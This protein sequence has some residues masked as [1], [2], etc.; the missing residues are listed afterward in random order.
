M[1]GGR[2]FARNFH[3]PIPLIEENAAISD[4]RNY[5]QEFIEQGS[6]TEWNNPR[7]VT[8]TYRLEPVQDILKAAF[9][10]IIAFFHMNQA[11]RIEWLNQRVKI[12][13][14]YSEEEKE[15]L[16]QSHL[17]QPIPTIR[18]VILT[19]YMDEEH[20]VHRLQLSFCLPC[21]YHGTDRW[22]VA[23]Y[24]NDHVMFVFK[25]TEEEAG[26]EVYETDH[27]SLFDQDGEPIVF[28]EIN[29]LWPLEWNTDMHG[30]LAM[31]QR[32]KYNGKWYKIR[33][34]IRG[35]TYII[36]HGKKV[37]IRK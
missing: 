15:T 19:P 7:I 36:V 14:N 13:E 32:Y 2:T 10:E 27:N 35:G 18:H 8:R 24:H 17:I 12:A 3:F 37:Y 16:L 33:D 23:H 25:T 11:Q 29:S 20:H 5:Y 26:N 4:I 6:V 28:L 34:G 9:S 21:R 22:I 30:G 31:T 1:F